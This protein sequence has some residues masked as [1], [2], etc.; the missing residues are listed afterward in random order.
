LSESGIASGVRRIEAAAG[1]EALRYWWLLRD[2]VRDTGRAVKG[3][4]EDLAEKVQEL[5]VRNKKLAKEMETLQDRLASD[6]GQDLMARLEEIAGIKTLIQKVE[7]RDM[8]ALRKIMDGL[9]SRLDSGIICLGAPGRDKAM[10]VLHVSRDLHERFTAPQL[11]KEAAAEIGGSGGGRPD[12][13][14][15]GGPDSLGLD[16]ALDKVRT[17]I[18]G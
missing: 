16:R 1:W 14:Q 2:A 15:A 10:L 3:R 5:V 8:G 6:S 17:L 12:M 7:A 9:R 11:I 13:A 18:A 4:P